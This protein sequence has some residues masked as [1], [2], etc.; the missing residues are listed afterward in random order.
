MRCVVGQALFRQLHAGGLAA[1]DF[2]RDADEV[3]AFDGAG[4]FFDGGFVLGGFEH[5]V[6]GAEG[7]AEWIELQAEVSACGEGEGL[8]GFLLLLELSCWVERC[9]GRR[10]GPWES[11]L[12]RGAVM[13]LPSPRRRSGAARGCGFRRRVLTNRLGN[14]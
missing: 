1:A 7:L 12:P 6:G 8:H 14:R 2:A 10:R 11:W 9:I 13:T 3:L 4:D 5:V